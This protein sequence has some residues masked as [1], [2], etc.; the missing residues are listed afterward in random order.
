MRGEMGFF[1]SVANG[2]ASAASAVGDAVEGAVDTVADV[3]EDTVDTVVDGV[4]GGI[5]RGA[6]WVCKNDGRVGC[7]AANLMGGAIDGILEGFQGILDNAFGAVRDIGGMIGSIFRLDLPGFL[8]HLGSFIINIV[9]G[10]IKSVRFVAL[11]YVVGGIVRYFKRSELIRF[12][13]RLLARRFEGESLSI[14]RDRIGLGGGQ[15]FGLRVEAEHRLCTLDSDDV[16]L[17][18]MHRDGTIDL[19]ALA[20][21]LSFNSFQLFRAAHPDSTVRL[22]GPDG[23]DS[24]QPVGRSVVSRHIET[25]GQSWRLRVYPMSKGR[26]AER[27]GVTK[28]LFEDLGIILNWNDGTRYATFSSYARQP[29]TEQEYNFNYSNLMQLLSTPEYNR[30]RTNCSVLSLA[31]FTSSNFGQAVGKSIDE[32]LG[33]PPLTDQA[34]CDTEL[35]FQRER[36]D[37]C[38]MEIQACG[39]SGTIYRDLFPKQ[40][41]QYVLPHE[42]GHFFGLCHCGHDGPQNIMFRPDLLDFWDWG[43]LSFYWEE[44]PHFS[45]DDAKNSWLF[46][47]DELGPC[48]NGSAPEIVSD[49]VTTGTVGRAYEYSPDVMGEGPI[50]WCLDDGPAGMSINSSTGVVSW[51]PSAEGEFDVTVAAVNAL[52]DNV[53][54]F[55]IQVDRGPVI[56]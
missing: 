45:L 14:A 42:I 21:L 31:A 2:V 37:L 15:K 48:L 27:L 40:V 11:G 23:E 35:G 29:V 28:R 55:S 41:F 20:G 39:R 17:W 10:I 8:K 7:G 34:S 52:R 3:V 33:S 9:N 19:Y 6:E 26:V 13:D 1:S 36:N 51:I 53:Q 56:E 30:D 43:I 16:E 44:E 12:V 38:C 4:Q 24:F 49:P 18:R 25:E 54:Q 32:C 47:V 50:G 22:V 46:I 5:R